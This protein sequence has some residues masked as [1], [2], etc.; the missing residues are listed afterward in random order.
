MATSQAAI[1]QSID[2]VVPEGYELEP[3]ATVPEGYE[4]E[5]ATAPTPS[6]PNHVQRV[7]PATP[8]P[9]TAAL[10]TAPEAPETMAAQLQQLV[11]GQRKVVMYP[12][13]TAGPV[14]YPQNTA[15]TS[16]FAGNVY[17][18]RPDLIKRSVIKKAA[19]NNKLHE[20]LGSTQMGMGTVDK[21]ELP[22]NAPVV[23]ARDRNGAE[24]QSTATSTAHLQRT[25]A[26]TKMLMP[27][28]GTVAVRSLPD[29]L[30]MRES[31]GAISDHDPI[32]EPPGFY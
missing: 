1:P 8:N 23:V 13:G 16:D 4:V 5:A 7:S 10:P 18:F 11:G 25:V 3:E 6:E 32:P 9:P 26:A 2:P 21:S 20:I 14:N 19:E 31:A 12:R 29:V 17:L 22:P 30:A 27:P 24:V 15:L 28:G